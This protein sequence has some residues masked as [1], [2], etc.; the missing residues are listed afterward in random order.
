MG[1][2]LIQLIILAGI[3]LFLILRL[4]SVLGT[5]TGFEKHPDAAR[6]PPSR[7]RD[8]RNL[9]VIEGGATDHDI[10]DFIDP[11]SESGRAIAA[12]KQAEPA[13]R[14]AKFLGGAK[15][16]YEHILM[17]FE[18]GEAEVLQ[19]LLSPEVYTSFTDVIDDR[20]SRGW[21]VE[22]TFAGIREARVLKAEFDPKNK[23]ADITIRFGADL[24]SVVRDAKGK[25]IEG[26]PDAIRRQSDTWTFSRV[27][28]AADPNWILVGT[29]S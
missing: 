17:A 19:D 29:G 7:S 5:R 9:Q 4:R 21:T 11:A 1:S 3:A 2:T 15:K 27:M 8:D 12:M 16:A 25:V 23:E 13:F 28:G 18:R 6:M 10:A 14:L 24:T 22:S 26:S 20:K